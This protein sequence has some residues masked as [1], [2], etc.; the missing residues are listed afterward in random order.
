MLEEGYTL[1]GSGPGQY[2]SILENLQP[3]TRYY[4]R[5]YA[6]VGDTIYYGAQTAFETSSACFIATAAYGSIVHP[7]VGV[8]RQ[9]R[10]RYL[11]TNPLGRRLVAWYYTHSPPIADRIAA[12]ALLRGLTRAALVPLVGISWLLLHPVTLMA[13]F[14]VLAAAGFARMYR[15]EIR[16][17]RP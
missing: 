15:Q 16:S 12:S 6:I 10:D 3:D 1:D 2:S 11:K 17:C 4:V 7:A 8:L 13:M 14:A 9:F 5:A